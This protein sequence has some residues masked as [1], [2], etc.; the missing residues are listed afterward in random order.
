[1]TVAWPPLIAFVLTWCVH[2]VQPCRGP[3]ETNLYETECKN[4]RMGQFMC[5]DPEY[6]LIDPKTQQLFGC[7]KDNVAQGVLI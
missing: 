5:P 6:E 3:G 2:L 1:M 7:T 4:L